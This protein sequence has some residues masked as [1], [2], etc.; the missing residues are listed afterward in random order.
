M[1]CVNWG[2]IDDKI[3]LISLLKLAQSEKFGTNTSTK[4]LMRST[5]SATLHG[6]EKRKL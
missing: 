5:I 6:D 1:P 4:I 2:D 3:L